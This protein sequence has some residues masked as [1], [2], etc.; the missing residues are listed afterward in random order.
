M[1]SLFQPPRGIDIPEAELPILELTTDL[2][3]VKDRRQLGATALGVVHAL[4]MVSHPTYDSPPELVV[5]TPEGE[6]ITAHGTIQWRWGLQVNMVPGRPGASWVDI[7][8]H[9]ID[10]PR[11]DERAAQLANTLMDGVDGVHEIET[12]EPLPTEERQFLQGRLAGLAIAQ[13]GRGNEPIWPDKFI[14]RHH[15]LMQ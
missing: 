1:H 10:G 5:F 14:R 13:R 3:E 11:G 8:Q 6:L 4:G 9:I 2:I 15:P 7:M 12:G